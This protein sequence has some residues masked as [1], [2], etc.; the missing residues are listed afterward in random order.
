MTMKAKIQVLTIFFV[1]LL[2]QYVESK[3][4]KVET[5]TPIV[6]EPVLQ[7]APVI[8]QKRLTTTTTVLIC[9]LAPPGLCEEG[10]I[11]S[12]Y[13]TCSFYYDDMGCFNGCSCITT[14]FNG[15][16]PPKDK[17]KNTDTP[18]AEYYYY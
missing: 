16:A 2:L 9:S 12:H 8:F 1:S 6:S 18:A 4:F 13:V 5:T 15:L 3:C 17:F 14:N 11:N 7:F 10:W